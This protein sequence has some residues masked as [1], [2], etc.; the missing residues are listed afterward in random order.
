MGSVIDLQARQ[1]S[2]QTN[3]E[4]TDMTLDVRTSGEDLTGWDRGKIVEALMRETGLDQQTS[5]EISIEV[6]EVIKKAKIK[7]ITAPLIRELV[8]SKLIERGLEEIRKKHTRLGVPIYD[9]DQLIL[10]PNKENA[11]VPHGP[12][13]TNLTLAE[14]IKKEYALLRVFSPEI[15]DAH[16]RGDIHLH[17]LGFIDRPYCSGQSLEYIKK[18]GLSLPNSLSIA[19]PAK[20]PEVQIKPSLCS[21][22]YCLSIRGL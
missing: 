12:E 9:V 6:E 16:M 5:D 13:A 21:A 18:F 20:Q 2:E 1:K 15:G 4:T 17:D 11:N 19:K 3:T 22:R 8:D 14:G 7:C 10:H